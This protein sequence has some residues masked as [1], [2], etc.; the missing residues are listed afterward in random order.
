MGSSIKELSNYR[1]SRAKEDLKTAK[2]NHENV[3][4]KASI[5]IG[6]NVVS[7]LLKNQ[8]K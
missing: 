8:S 2:L 1:L 7:K 4:Y 3:M 5:N 6:Y